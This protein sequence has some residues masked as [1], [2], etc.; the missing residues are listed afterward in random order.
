MRRFVIAIAC[1]AMAAAVGCESPAPQY[2]TE[3]VDVAP[4]PPAPAEPAPQAKPAPAQ[5]PAANAE[6]R[7]VAKRRVAGAGAVSLGLGHEQ[8]TGGRG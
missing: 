6:H 4:A 1:L 2:S 8:F 5:E 3:R 7:V